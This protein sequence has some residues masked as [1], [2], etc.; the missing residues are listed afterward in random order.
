[1]QVRQYLHEVTQVLVL[2]EQNGVIIH[3][4]LLSDGM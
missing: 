2:A 4:Y 3:K 1:M